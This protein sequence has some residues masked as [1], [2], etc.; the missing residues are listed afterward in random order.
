M[1]SI[2]LTDLKSHDKKI[3]ISLKKKRNT[4]QEVFQLYLAD[5]QNLMFLQ[6][7]Y[8]TSQCYMDIES[9]SMKPKGSMGNL[10]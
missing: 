3:Q 7:Q 8:D 5:T 9:T 4:S 6:H 10:V 1:A 2:K